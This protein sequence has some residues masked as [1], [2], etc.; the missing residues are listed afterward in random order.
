MP[1]KIPE[2]IGDTPDTKV[3]ARVKRRV[4]D[5]FDGV[6]Q[7]SKI[8]IQPGMKWELHHLLSLEAGG[9]HRE[10]NLVPV[11]PEFHKR[12]TAK[13]MAVKKKVNRTRNKHI[14]VTT[15]KGGLKSK[16]F[17]KADKSSKI[18]KSAV[19][20]AAVRTLSPLQRQM[21]IKS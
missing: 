1:R 7:L 12:E 17:T 9:E 18:D 3:P 2:W 21:G 14:G 11:L 13:Q 6:C 4:F 19:D 16:G 10:E 8:K 5:R 15:P 20:A